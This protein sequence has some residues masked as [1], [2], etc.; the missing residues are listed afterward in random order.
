[1]TFFNFNPL[2]VNSLEYVSM[3]NQEC[4]TRTKIKI[5]NNNE[6]V[7]YP[8]SI[9]V[10]KCSGSCNNI[11]DSYAKLCVPDVAKKINVKIFNLMSFSNKKKHIKCYETCKCKCGLDVSIC[12][13]KQ[14]WNEDKC[15]CECRK[16]LNDKQSCDKGFISNP[17]NCNCECDKSCNIGKYLDYKN[18]KCRQKIAGSLV[19]EC[20]KNIDEKEN[21]YN[22][23]LNVS[24][25]DYKRGS[26]TLYIVLFIVFLVTSAIISDA[27]IYFY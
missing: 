3:N 27:F 8:F 6:S 22:K 11:N 13:N 18:C 17:S 23:T 12:K 25:S 16:E 15:R 20:S 26:C 7:F 9:K 1:M 14:R 19:E 10:N 4:K 24:L 5:I 21:I 2:N